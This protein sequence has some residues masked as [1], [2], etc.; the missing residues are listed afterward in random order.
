[1]IARSLLAAIVLGRLCGA[2]AV[3]EV[4]LFDVAPE[5]A[6]KAATGGDAT[7]PV[8]DTGGSQ[9]GTGGTAAEA[10]GG[11]QVTPDSSIAGSGAVAGMPDEPEGGTPGSGGVPE[12]AGQGSGGVMEAAGQGSGGVASGCAN[13]TEC[14]SGW[15]CHTPY[16][17]SW[18]GVCEPREVICDSVP[19][20]VCGCDGTTYWNE[21]I[22]RQMGTG[23][24]V[25]GECG[26]TAKSCDSRMDCGSMVASCSRLYFQYPACPSLN[27]WTELPPGLCWVT[28]ARCDPAATADRW[29]GCPPPGGTLPPPN[30]RNCMDTCT[31]IN[32]PFPAFLAHFGDGCI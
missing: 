4:P 31:A 12:A 6:G 2:C 5:T 29:I 14:A 3:R 1:M 21:C 27:G 11:V 16:C 9:H 19:N 25:P 32:Y 26:A 28:P 13:D 7:T 30:Q 15:F 22:W 23:A 10:S 18:L 8:Q 24:F 17:G 20:P